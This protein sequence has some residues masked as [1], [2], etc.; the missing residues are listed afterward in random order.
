MYL[1]QKLSLNSNSLS[2]GPKIRT[3]KP[4]VQISNQ[5]QK[6]RDRL[7]QIAEEVTKISSP[8][9]KESHKSGQ[10]KKPASKKHRKDDAAKG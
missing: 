8:E 10:S 9:S 7:G 3:V 1:P 4:P 2:K 6:V 5:I